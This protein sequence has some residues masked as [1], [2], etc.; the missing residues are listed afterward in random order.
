M[1][2]SWAAVC[3]LSKTERHMFDTWFGKQET[4]D[5]SLSGSEKNGNGNCRSTE[6]NEQ[7]KRL[8]GPG[9]AAGDWPNRKPATPPSPPAFEQI[10]QTATVKPPKLAYGIQK[11]ADMGSSAHLAGMSAVFKRKALL[12]ALEAAGTDVGEVLNDVVTRQRALKEYEES[13]LDKVSQFESAQT[14]QIR[15]QKAELDR[16]TSQFKARIDASLDEVEQWHDGFRQ[17]Q[18]SKQQELQRLT[19]A[20]ALCVSHDAAQEDEEDESDGKVMT[21]AQRAGGSYR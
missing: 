9:Q 21:I 2:L 12:M 17:W 20:A 1:H 13:Y 3:H 6:R 18:K 14:E 11:V 5:L 10:Y 4:T 8:L 16:I 15:L 19:E 7:V